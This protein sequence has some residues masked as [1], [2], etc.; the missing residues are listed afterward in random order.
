MKG[1]DNQDK[2]KNDDKTKQSDLIK[3]ED[4]KVEFKTDPDE[5]SIY[6]T[7]ETVEEVRMR[8]IKES[9]I[10]VNSGHA[11]HKYPAGF[12]YSMK[13]ERIYDLEKI[14]VKPFK[15]LGA[16]SLIQSTVLIIGGGLIGTSIAFWL[17]E[18][19]T[20]MLDVNVVDR[21]F[22]V[23]FNFLINLYTLLEQS[24]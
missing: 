18:L 4:D 16:I 5:V 1:N 9:E 23:N 12:N 3:R 8:L 24:I 14:D 6:D 21:D 20:N 15:D 2:S 17:R 19:G 13:T 7:I 22:K 11:L 10:C